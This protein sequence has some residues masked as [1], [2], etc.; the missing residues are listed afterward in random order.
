MY[1]FY[2]L[3]IL[4]AVVVWFLLSGVYRP[5]GRLG[6]RVWQDAVDNMAEEPEQ[7]AAASK[8]TT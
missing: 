6:K 1:V 7:P 4:A 2:F 5:L 8:E 3:V